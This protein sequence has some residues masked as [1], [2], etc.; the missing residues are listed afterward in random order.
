ML[1]LSERSLL[2]ECQCC[3][4]H[5]SVGRCFTVWQLALRDAGRPIGVLYTMQGQAQVHQVTHDAKR[6]RT[7]QN[8]NAG[9]NQVCLQGCS[10]WAPSATAGVK[11]LHMAGRVG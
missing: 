9:Y 7:T 3:E 4:R 1:L 8:A 5:N 2:S 6:Q 11:L 10:L